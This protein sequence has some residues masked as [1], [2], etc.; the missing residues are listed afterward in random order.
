[1]PVQGEGGNPTLVLG[2]PAKDKLAISVLLHASF[3]VSNYAGLDTR[4]VAL[5]TAQE[6]SSVC[7]L[8]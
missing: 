6:C 7:P 8:S 5:G 4:I 2:V 1:M 3:V